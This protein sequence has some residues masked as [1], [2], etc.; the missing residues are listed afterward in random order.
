[1]LTSK[2]AHEKVN[3]RLATALL[4]WGDSRAFR[5]NPDVSTG[6]DANEVRRLM[7][8]SGRA[9]TIRPLRHAGRA[10]FVYLCFNE[11][12]RPF[13][14]GL[15]DSPERAVLDAFLVWSGQSGS[16]EDE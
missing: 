6:A 13:A 8:G 4:R 14:Q 7:E 2:D 1:M 11:R 16:F 12:G 10:A 3:R 15:G 5:L 9:G